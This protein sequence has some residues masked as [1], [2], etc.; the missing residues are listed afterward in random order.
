MPSVVL[1]HVLFHPLV[2]LSIV[3]L[4]DMSLLLVTESLTILPVHISP[5]KVTLALPLSPSSPAI[6]LAFLDPEL[7]GPVSTVL[8]TAVCGNRLDVVSIKGTTTTDILAVIRA[9]DISSGGNSDK[10]NKKDQHI[11]TRELQVL[12]Y[13]VIVAVVPNPLYPFD[14]PGRCIK[15]L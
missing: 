15:S 2:L 8:E 12:N 4:P 7:G 1:H 9:D 14:I 13:N 3:R 6:G 11:V 5:L 10:E